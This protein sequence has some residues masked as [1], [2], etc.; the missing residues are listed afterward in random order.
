MA[1]IRP[2]GF[3]NTTPSG[4]TDHLQFR[5]GLPSRPPVAQLPSTPLH[6]RRVMGR[7]V[8]LSVRTSPGPDVPRLLLSG[9]P[10][11]VG[12][13]ETGAYRCRE[14]RFLAVRFMKYPPT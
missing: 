4:G 8:K 13:Y 2:T 3:V 7:R 14:R 11:V 12:A 5:G 9:D 6:D 1:T 10:G